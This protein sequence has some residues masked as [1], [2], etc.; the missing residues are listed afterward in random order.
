MFILPDGNTYLRAGL[1]KSAFKSSIYGGLPLDFYLPGIET[2]SVLTRQRTV[3]VKF[4]ML[5]D[6]YLAFYRPY[7]V[8]M[9]SLKARNKAAPVWNAYMRG[10]TS[11]DEFYNLNKITANSQELAAAAAA[12]LLSSLADARVGVGSNGASR[13]FT[14]LDDL[15]REVASGKPPQ[16][17]KQDVEAGVD[18]YLRRLKDVAR[19]VGYSEGKLLDAIARSLLDYLDAR[20]GGEAAVSAMTGGGSGGTGYALEALSIWTFLENPVEFRRRVQLLHNAHRMFRQFMSMSTTFDRQQVAQQHGGVAGVT[21]MRDLAQLRDLLPS[22]A[23]LARAARALFAAKLARRE[24]LIHKRAVTLR[25]VIFV[26]K[27]GSMGDRMPGGVEKISAAAGLALALHR[28][29]GG[30]IYLFDTEVE[31]VKPGDVVRTL[32]TISAYGG[33]N[34]DPVLSEIL[35]LGRNYVHIII[36]DGITEASEEL[37]QRFAASGLADRTRLILIP[38]ASDNYRWVTLLKQRGNL[39]HANDVAS[40]VNAA[41]EALS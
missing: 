18:K 8:V 17:V 38:P 40:F 36:S 26:D 19:G 16:D 15:A 23:A 14:E 30:L 13:R 25:P 10:L 11:T 27:S 7:E 21:L 24:L 29:F 37:L 3:H 33:T 22:E 34:I 41:R 4:Y 9:Q 32:L 20:A 12:L 35:R 5:H 1:A 31:Q 28:R 39:F 2:A 6:A